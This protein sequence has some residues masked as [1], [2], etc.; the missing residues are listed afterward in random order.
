MPC[1]EESYNQS[2]WVNYQILGFIV[3]KQYGH[4]RYHRIIGQWLTSYLHWT[5]SG[6][7]SDSDSRSYGYIVLCRTCS[8]RTDSDSDPSPYPSM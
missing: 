6:A 2:L 8:H 7:D 4:Q 1:I 5:D 3:S